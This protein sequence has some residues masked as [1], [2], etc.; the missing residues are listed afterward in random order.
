M[1]VFMDSF[2]LVIR[3]PSRSSLNM[4]G[5][6][7]G[8]RADGCQVGVCPIPCVGARA[9]GTAAVGLAPAILASQTAG[10]AATPEALA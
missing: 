5:G 4:T 9:V 3:V 6:Q 7:R 10:V 8:L 1:S 2:S